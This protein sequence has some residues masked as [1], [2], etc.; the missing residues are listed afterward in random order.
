MARAAALA[1][2]AVLAGCGGSGAVATRP[3]A[4]PTPS[5][6]RPH[7]APPTDDQQ[8]AALLRRRAAALEAGDRRAYAGTATRGQRRRDRAAAAR[9]GRLNLREVTLEP[10]KIEFHGDRATARVTLA[11]GIAGIRSSFAS[12]R[13]VD[14]VR[15]G[16][17]WRIV[18]E[19]GRRGVPPWEVGDFA[20][21]RTKHFVVLAPPTA[22]V[23]DILASLESG[24]GTIRGVLAQGRVRRRY[25]VVVAGDATQARAL[26]TEIRGV[27]T[28][29]AISDAAITESGPERQT[30][31]VLS[32]RLVVVLPAFTAL[33]PD[34]R[35]R[36]ITHELTHAALTGATS[37]RTPS[38]LVEGVALYVSGDRRPA[39]PGADLSALSAPGAIA[40]ASGDAQASAYAVSSA[41]AFA[42]ADRFGER[43]LLKLY[44]AFN[45]PKL[46]GA[47]GP[48]LVRRA[49]RRELGVSLAEIQAGM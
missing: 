18:R 14:L 15:V 38:W 29:A 4:T 45:D 2:L 6:E 27:E 13:R 32:L 26:T 46:I 39:P 36:L 44:D 17:H 12:T 42:I 47:P 35:G 30:V 28:L 3:A 43:R 7:E 23:D 20:E 11:Y 48:R 34:G 25:L 49:V 24:Y 22:S 9:A 5:A 21:R 33:G 19:H 10:G 16:E 8:I 31:D 41:A 40:R 1:A 37:G